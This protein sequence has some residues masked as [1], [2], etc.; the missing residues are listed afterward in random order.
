MKIEFESAEE[1]REWVIGLIQVLHKSGWVKSI[2]I[3][4][5]SDDG[6]NEQFY[7]I[8]NYIKES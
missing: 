1:K 7:V 2:E 3:G 5:D 6:V 4:G 8:D